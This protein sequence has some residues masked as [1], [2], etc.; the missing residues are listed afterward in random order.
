MIH[1]HHIT[2][3]IS[4]KI[5]KPLFCNFLDLQE[6]IISSQGVKE[7]SSTGTKSSSPPLT[8][9]L[10]Q[11]PNLPPNCPLQSSLWKLLHQPNQNTLHPDKS[12]V[13]GK[14]IWAVFLVKTVHFHAFLF[15]KSLPSEIALKGKA[16]G[17][18][19]NIQLI[20]NQQTTQIYTQIPSYTVLL[21]RS[22]WLLSYC[23]AR[24]LS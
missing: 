6:S 5:N 10:K 20:K 3:Y 16:E 21:N 11:Q 23:S 14:K 15:C 22:S 17:D 24:A 12:Q 1:F 8:A 19:K 18:G 9:S 2:I 7:S 4:K 13:K